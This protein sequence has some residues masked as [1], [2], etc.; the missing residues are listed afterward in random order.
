VIFIVSRCLYFLAGVR[1]D[2]EPLQFYWQIVDP[3]LLHEA[4]WQSLSYLRGQVPGFNFFVGTIIHLFPEH[5]STSFH[6]T[7]LCLD[8]IVAI[9][10]FT[11]LDR[12]RVGKHLVS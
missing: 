6:A 8:L 2:M 3:V 11:L 10:L 5:Q 1:F 9:Y 7:Y 12:T 4:F